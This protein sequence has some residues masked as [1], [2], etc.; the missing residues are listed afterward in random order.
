MNNIEEL[1]KLFIKIELSKN[2]ISIER[3]KL[4]NMFYELQ[5]VVETFDDG[6]NTLEESLNIMEK[7]IDTLSQYI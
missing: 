2:I 5:E 7:S 4:R 1:K 3:D 6:V